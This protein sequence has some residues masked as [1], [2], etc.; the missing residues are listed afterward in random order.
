MAR[1][2]VQKIKTTTAVHGYILRNGVP[3]EASYEIGRRVGLESAQAIVRKEEP[4]FMAA[5]VME[6]RTL[7]T[8]EF[9]RFYE[10]ADA[11]PLEYGEDGEDGE[12]AEDAED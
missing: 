2:Y 12:D 11:R 8:M 10:L 5:S 1:N 7:Y 3:V 4:S 9:N 6:H